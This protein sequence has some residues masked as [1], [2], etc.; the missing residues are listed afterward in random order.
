MTLWRTCHGK[1]W[2]Q[3]CLKSAQ[4]Q[5]QCLKLN[6]KSCRSLCLESQ[7]MNIKLKK[8]QQKVPTPP[9]SCRPW[10][11][12]PVGTSNSTEPQLKSSRCIPVFGVY[13]TLIQVLLSTPVSPVF[14]LAPLTLIEWSSKKLTFFIFKKPD[15]SSQHSW[16]RIKFLKFYS[17]VLNSRTYWNGRHSAKFAEKLFVEHLEFFSHC[18]DCTNSEMHLTTN[19][20]PMPLIVSCL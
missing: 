3:V 16:N 15:L 18:S 7:I 20:T 9:K 19:S 10:T 8:N 17:V 4:M 5:N 14:F 2:Q 13:S 1:A 11:G 12:G 6:Q